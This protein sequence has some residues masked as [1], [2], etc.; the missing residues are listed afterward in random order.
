MTERRKF[1]LF[2]KMVSAHELAFIA[3]LSYAD[4]CDMLAQ[5]KTAESIVTT[6][7]LASDVPDDE[8]LAIWQ[9]SNIRVILRQLLRKHS[10][11]EAV[12]KET[13]ISQIELEDFYDGTEAKLSTALQ[14]AQSVGLSLEC[15]LEGLFIVTN[16]GVAVRQRRSEMSGQKRTVASANKKQSQR[17]P[18]HTAMAGRTCP[19]CRG[20]CRYRPKQTER[21]AG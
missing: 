10:S 4:V 17:K 6:P 7:A 2:G 5:G 21:K 12:S 16:Q 18:E 11:W 8:K 14:I 3:E 9:E 15:A 20:I 19:I 1:D 13:C